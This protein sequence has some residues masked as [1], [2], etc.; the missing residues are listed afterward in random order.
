MPALRTIEDL[1]GPRGLPVVG[2]AMQLDPTGFH[3]TLEHWAEQYGSAFRIDIGP[4][5]MLCLTQPETI[6]T[7]LRDRPEGFGRTR[8]LE[9]VFQEIGAP[10]VFSSNG[11]SWRRQRKLVMGA[12]DA[13]H[14]EAF[15][16]MLQRVAERLLR[17]WAHA[18]DHDETIDV[19]SDL[20]RFTVDV[21]TGLALGRDLNTIESETTPLRDDLDRIFS[22]LNRRLRSPFPLWRW[23]RSAQDRAFERAL[24]R[25]QSLTARLVEE[26]RAKLVEN[27]RPQNLIEAL[28]VAAATDAEPLGE[29]EVFG[30]VL[31]ILLGGEDTTANTLAWMLHYMTLDK[32]LQNRAA[33]EADRVLGTAP[34]P[35]CYGDLDRLPWIDAI[36][37]EAMRMRPVGPVISVQPTRACAIEDIE[38]PRDAVVLLLMRPAAIDPVNFTDAHVFRPERWI[39]PPKVHEAKVSMPFGAGTRFCP[40]RRLAM[41]EIRTVM[42]SICRA[43]TFERACP[44]EV[45]ERFAITMQ[46]VGLRFRIRRRVSSCAPL[47]EFRRSSAQA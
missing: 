45:A 23:V 43:F 42:A 10:S 35:A 47:H 27:P 2:N 17:R 33:Q 3:R 5:R 40:G 14:V 12:L 31:A 4:R 18:A 11:D 19:Q 24:A 39:G 32:S 13:R 37:C 44:N 21:T 46:P 29:Q 36:A 15:F 8:L 41:A 9:S 7:V 30:N 28:L 22:T 25:I 38:V 6:S 26:A 20:M 1:P 34:V 16:P